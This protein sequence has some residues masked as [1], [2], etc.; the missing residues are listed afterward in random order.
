M[1]MQV[2]N[3]IAAPALRG[4]SVLVSLN[5]SESANK[6]PSIYNGEK[7]TVSSTGN[8]GYV[9]SVDIYGTSF[10]VTPR[11]PDLSFS[12]VQAGYLS[13]GEIITLI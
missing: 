13:A 4:Q 2:T 3:Q 1:A 6:L 10:E 9:S 11:N 5:A 8:V 7:A 12:S